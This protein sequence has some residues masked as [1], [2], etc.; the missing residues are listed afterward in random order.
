M[1]QAVF[2]ENFGKILARIRKMK[3]E[4]KLRNTPDRACGMRCL[5]TA[6]NRWLRG[7]PGVGSGH[8]PRLLAGVGGRSFAQGYRSGRGRHVQGDIEGEGQ[9]PRVVV[10]RRMV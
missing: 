1:M 7:G 6:W 3:I 9:R 4:M 5:T 2:G 10:A 8:P